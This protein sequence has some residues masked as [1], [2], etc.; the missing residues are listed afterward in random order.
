MTPTIRA[1]Y[2]SR[3]QAVHRGEHPLVLERRGDDRASG[4]WRGVGGTQDGEVVGLGAAPRED[5]FAGSAAET[6]RDV[7][8]CG[9]Q[10]GLRLPGHD[11]ET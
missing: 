4:P 7:F 6:I 8:A 3:G 5:H 10:G 2:P 9:F 1:V 11:V